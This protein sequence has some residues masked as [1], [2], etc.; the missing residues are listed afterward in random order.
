M[1]NNDLSLLFTRM[2]FV[3]KDSRD[4]IVEDRQGFVKCDVVLASI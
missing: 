4:W 3:V 1:S 2:G